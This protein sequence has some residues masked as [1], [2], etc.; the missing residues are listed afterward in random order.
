[1]HRKSQKEPPFSKKS[2]V[3]IRTKIQKSPDQKHFNTWQG[4]IKEFGA[5]KLSKNPVRP[6]YKG[7]D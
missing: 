6:D 1:M 3:L 7:P 5:P 2:P 4:I